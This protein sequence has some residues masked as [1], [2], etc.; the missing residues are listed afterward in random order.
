[1]MKCWPEK[2]PLLNVWVGRFIP[3]LNHR[4][5]DSVGKHQVLVS[6]PSRLPVWSQKTLLRQRG[7]H[8]KAAVSLVQLEIVSAAL[9]T[10]SCGLKDYNLLFFLCSEGAAAAGRTMWRGRGL[11]MRHLQTDKSVSGCVFMG[12]SKG[13]FQTFCGFIYFFVITDMDIYL[14][15]C[16]GVIQCL[17]HC[18][19]RHWPLC[20]PHKENPSYP[21]E[22]QDSTFFL[23]S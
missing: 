20:S 11:V 3:G 19:H 12:H 17:V 22:T 16:S 7:V 6:E 8:Y 9:S 15:C 14:A 5:S 2:C 4:E 1:M 21:A 18:F 23:N 13:N 10:A